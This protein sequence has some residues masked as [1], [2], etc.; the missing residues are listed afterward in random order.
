MVRPSAYRTW[1]FLSTAT[2]F[3]NTVVFTV[4][5]VYFVAELGTTPF[6]LVFIGTLMEITVF[7]FEIPTGAFADSH[8]RRSSVVVAYLVQGIGFLVI[9]SFP[10]YA[11][12]LA[13]YVIW[14]IGATFSSGALEAWITD[15][16]EGRDL[17]SVFLRGVQF[18][19]AGQLA[20]LG[21]AA[22]LASVDLALPFTVGGVLSLMLGAALAL[23]MRED[24]WH[25]ATGP[26]S[27]SRPRLRETAAEG[28]RMVREHRL[29]MPV[30]GFVALLGAYTESL[31][32]LWEAHLL[33]A[34]R[35]PELG[36]L[37]PVVWFGII[38][39]VGLVLGICIM[40]AVAPRL[41]DLEP[42]R[43]LRALRFLTWLQFAGLLTFALAGYF[44]LAIAALFLTNL[45]RGIAGSLFSA[46]INREIESSHR[47]TV[48]SIVNQ[49]DAVG[50]WIGGPAIGVVGTVVSLRA[51]LA[52]GAAILLP[53]VRSLTSVQRRKE[54][55]ATDAT[56][57]P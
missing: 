31:D 29:L 50:Q 22:A 9:G 23:T 52:M 33:I 42:M 27:S 32:R 11:A 39:A 25:P 12:V 15:E 41:T 4:A 14:G 26:L 1:L 51:A 45:A 17:E 28:I 10:S 21:T 16:M 20:G 55:A 40:G 49:S 43:S 47:A 38:G 30:L 3:I 8:G 54:R 48:L 7:L 56:P 18:W 6:Q 53:A 36:D 35:F 24:R 5:A 2:S 44:Y 46:W 57:A 19:A 34:F 37:E 13:G